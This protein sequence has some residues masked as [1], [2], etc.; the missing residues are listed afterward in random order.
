L[1]VVQ[2]P[3]LLQINSS[4]DINAEEYIEIPTGPHAESGVDD[5]FF[6]S[7]FLRNSVHV[8]GNFD[9]STPGPSRTLWRTSLGQYIFDKL[10]M[11]HLHSRTPNQP[12]E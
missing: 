7:E 12:M 3:H 2:D 6:Q 11:S 4:G 10:G 5:P 1:S 8:V 9:P